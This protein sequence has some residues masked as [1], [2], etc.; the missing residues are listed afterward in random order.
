MKVTYAQKGKSVQITLAST[1]KQVT[2]LNA[3][4]PTSKESEERSVP[5]GLHS[6]T[7]SKT[8]QFTYYYCG[9]REHMKF[10]CRKMVGDVR[11]LRLQE[12]KEEHE[13][14][15]RKRN[16]FQRLEKTNLERKKEM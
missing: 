9:L 5:K 13:K 1:S 16:Y 4:S 10:E 7:R 14:M 2:Y 15:T 12:K 11:F 3:H 8:P 6:V